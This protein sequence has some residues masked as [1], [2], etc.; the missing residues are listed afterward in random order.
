MWDNKTLGKTR[1]NNSKV[2]A[3]TK[4][5]ALKILLSSLGTLQT[6]PQFQQQFLLV[7]VIE[8]HS[9]AGQILEEMDQN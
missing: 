9:S 1:E 3:T 7:T 8:V 5:E 6:N 2:V 4:I